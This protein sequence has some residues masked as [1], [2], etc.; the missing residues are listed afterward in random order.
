MSKTTFELMHSEPLVEK[1]QNLFDRKT[2]FTIG[3]VN[4]YDLSSDVSNDI[5]N[6]NGFIGWQGLG[7]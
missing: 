5:G 3:G 4:V 1:D 6:I 7:N 2:K